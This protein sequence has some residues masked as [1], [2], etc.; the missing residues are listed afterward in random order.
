MPTDNIFE[1]VLAQ[2]MPKNKTYLLDFVARVNTYSGVSIDA[3][4]LMA[5]RQD[6]KS[7]V[8]LLPGSFLDI[9]YMRDVAQ[10]LGVDDQF[11]VWVLI[12]PDAYL[13]ILIPIG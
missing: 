1:E 11:S 6:A 3:P 12:I 10:G 2:I 5:S 7:S 13:A 4:K 9:G 8:I